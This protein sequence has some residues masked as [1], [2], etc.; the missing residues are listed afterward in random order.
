MRN[1][2]FVTSVVLSGV[3]D[4]LLM[5]PD[6][7]RT[8][9]LRQGL[10]ARDASLAVTLMTPEPEVG[11]DTFL[12]LIGAFGAVPNQLVV[13]SDGNYSKAI[14]ISNRAAI[15]PIHLTTTGPKTLYLKDGYHADIAVPVTAVATTPVSGTF[16][17]SYLH[18]DIPI[19]GISPQPAIVGGTGM[20]QVASVWSD[21]AAA[22]LNFKR[23]RDSY[24]LIDMAG[25]ASGANVI[26]LR[27]SAGVDLYTF[28]VTVSDVQQDTV[29]GWYVVAGT[30]SFV[31]LDTDE[32][33][34]AP[35]LVLPPA[36]TNYVAE[37]ASFDDYYGSLVAAD[38]MFVMAA[39]L[40]N[41]QTMPYA[42]YR[43]ATADGSQVF[44]SAAD[45]DGMVRIPKG[46]L[47][48]VF[49]IFFDYHGLRY[50]NQMF[51]KEVV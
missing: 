10:A 24:V 39:R 23:Y 42:S 13:S 49:Q 12:V 27:D 22:L 47:P 40:K 35:L 15:I 30:A 4:G 32:N 21:T 48:E 17:V 25:L 44:D 11:Q 8:L 46:L 20:L 29:A 37:S 7:P 14:A 2:V 18:Y 38:S 34:T 45:A 16:A 5:R 36:D 33:I 26:R 1:R 3:V 31:W 41:G 28:T 50:L 43:I 51:R 9:K 6:G 19:G